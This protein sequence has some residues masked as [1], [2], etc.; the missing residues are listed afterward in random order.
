MPGESD[1]LESIVLMADPRVTGVPISEDGE[2]LVD[3]RDYGLRVSSFR[4]DD[5]GDFAHV[6]AGLAARLV[7]AAEALPR[8]VRLLLIEGYRPPALQRRYFDDYLHSLREVSPGS[9]DE[10]L[11]L[12]ASRYVSPPEIAPHSAGAAIDLTLCDD[13]G[14]ELDLGT[15][16]NASP[17]QSGGACY[18]HHPSVG[19]QARRNRAT[20]AEA[21]RAAGLVNYPTEWWH[22]SHGD[23]YWAMAT[24]APSAIYGAVNRH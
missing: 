5:I 19:G 15:P 7:R 11:R 4:A 3:A 8:G 17:E 12:L 10:Q 21:L 16:V 9:N 24:S 14:T 18:T 20:L 2:D 23:R 13:D 22:W 6:R 1:P